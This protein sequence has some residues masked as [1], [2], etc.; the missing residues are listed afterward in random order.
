M[1]CQVS[2]SALSEKHRYIPCVIDSPDLPAAIATLAWQLT[3]KRDAAM[4]FHARVGQVKEKALLSEI[5]LV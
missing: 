1:L 3:V 2:I 5:G 4:H